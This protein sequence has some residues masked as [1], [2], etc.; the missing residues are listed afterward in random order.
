M[1]VPALPAIEQV[2]VFLSVEVK[3]GFQGSSPELW[4]AGETPRERGAGKGRITPLLLRMRDTRVTERCQGKR[5][6]KLEISAC[7]PVICSL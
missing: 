2:A 1:F 7:Q 3:Q 5:M 6:E 4:S